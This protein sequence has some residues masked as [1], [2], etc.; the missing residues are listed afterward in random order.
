ML[1]KCQSLTRMPWLGYT[2]L[3]HHDY[4]HHNPNSPDQQRVM[5]DIA[6]GHVEEFAYLLAKLKSMPAG[7]GTVLDH[8]CLLYIHE[9]AEANEHKNHGMIA[10]LTG[11]AGN[12]AT[13]SHTA[14]TGVIG[15]LYLSITNDVFGAKS[16][17]FP[18]ANQKLEGVVA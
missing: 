6:R 7:D 14:T 2:T 18:S 12:M 11:H 16:E 5:R 8:C 3:R 1:T 9:H 15:D 10:I 4:T 13:G 17:E